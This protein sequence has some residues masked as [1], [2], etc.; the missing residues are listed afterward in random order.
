MMAD[1]TPD[2][3]L[4]CRKL[5]CPMPVL[6]TKKAVKGMPAGKILEVLATDKAAPKDI[7]AW[8]KKAG[9]EVLK[10]E[11]DEE[12]KIYLKKSE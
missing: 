10:I 3:V 6:K 9:V 11:G 2:E 4:D 8:A 5:V 7:T 1:I 12:F